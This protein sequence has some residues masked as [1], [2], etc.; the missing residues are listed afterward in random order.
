M[1]GREHHHLGA[2]E[3][4]IGPDGSEYLEAGAEWQLQV[5]QHERR[6]SLLDQDP[7]LLAVA[8]L[9]H[10]VVRRFDRGVNESAKIWLVVDDQNRLPLTD[11][12][13]GDEAQP[14]TRTCAVGDSGNAM[15]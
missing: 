6:L 8:R 11:P 12:T 14:A 7:G 13:P 1:A 15:V 9:D 10:L 4:G 3:L 2:S 5:E